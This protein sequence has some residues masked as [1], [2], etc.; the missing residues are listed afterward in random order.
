MG[1]LLVSLRNYKK[2]HCSLTLVKKIKKEK[3]KKEE[4][5]RKPVPVFHLEEQTFLNLSFP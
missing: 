3:K 1:W 2:D 5:E 4:N